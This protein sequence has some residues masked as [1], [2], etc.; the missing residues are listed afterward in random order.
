[1]SRGGGDSA[2]RWPATVWWPAGALLLAAAF[3]PAVVF[4]EV[5][6]R[7]EDWAQA[8]AQVVLALSAV[9]L[10]LDRAHR[11]AAA[12]VG[13]TAVV[14]GVSGRGGLGDV[15]GGYWDQVGWVALWWPAVTLLPVLLSY[16]GER[17]TGRLPRALVG[18]MIGAVVVRA[19]G[20]PTWSLAFSDYSGPAEWLSYPGMTGPELSH[21]MLVAETV[22]VLAVVAGATVV[23][24]G[25]WRR[26]SGVSRPAVRAVAVAGVALA[27]AVAVRQVGDMSWPVSLPDRTSTLMVTFALLGVA[28]LVLLVIGIHGVARRAWLT[29]ALLR[30]GG[31]ARAVEATLQG[32]L[33]DPRLRLHFA[34][35]GG[36]ADAAGR[37]EGVGVGVG[38]LAAPA[39]GLERRLLPP[40]SSDASTVVDLSIVAPEDD[41]VVRSLLLAAS[42][43]TE[44][45]R[46]SVERTAHLREVSASRTRVVEAGL[47]ER[48]RLERDL[49]DG[50]QQH[51]LALS[52]TLARAELAGTVD[53]RSGAMADARD[54]VAQTMVELRRLARGIHP[55]ALSQAGLADALR[56]LEAVDD[57]VLV[58]VDP[59]LADGTRLDPTVESAAYFIAAEVVANALKHSGAGRITVTATVDDPASQP[60]LRLRV[61]DDGR[62]GASD[63][64]SGLIG[65]RDRVSSLGG[66]FAMDSGPGTGTIVDVWLPPAAVAPELGG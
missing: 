48:R 42:V 22:L 56:Q 38:A 27:L 4:I 55:T 17:V 2:V 33:R 63:Q 43:A 20:A 3:V 1:M 62:G 60:G 10:W 65:I 37:L 7:V 53:A 28:P 50:V 51:L 11:R 18:V 9:L 54:R 21:T 52:A 13:A 23:F 39:A 59:S 64:G 41:A 31:D 57:R 29:D 16:P 6:G 14:L 8:G 30:D 25:R 34:V 35:S 46:L 36:W 40:G 12:L 44:N 26:A 47:A 66:R 58:Q 19:V 32:A 5:T 24:V 15:Y 45:S 61:H 49:H